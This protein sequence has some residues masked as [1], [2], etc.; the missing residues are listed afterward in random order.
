MGKKLF[1]LFK[2]F[3]THNFFFFRDN[4]KILSNL[5]SE[6]A[7]YPKYDFSWKSELKWGV[8]SYAQKR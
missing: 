6:G 4:L 1:F 7:I 2:L 5:D 3:F 8:W